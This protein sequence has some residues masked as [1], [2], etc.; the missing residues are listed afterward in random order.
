MA[1]ALDIFKLIENT[2]KSIFLSNSKII[3]FT[4]ENFCININRTVSNF[5]KKSFESLTWF[6]EIGKT[7][8]IE[9]HILKPLEQIENFDGDRDIFAL[10]TSENNFSHCYAMINYILNNNT[11]NNL[12]WFGYYEVNQTFFFKKFDTLLTVNLTQRDQDFHDDLSVINFIE[13]H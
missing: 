7:D 6:T 9:Q 1:T 12:E 13:L 2:D 3:D 8:L 4:Y 10:L 11:S 5:I